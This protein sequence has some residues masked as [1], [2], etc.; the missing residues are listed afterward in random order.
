[1]R[2]G[3]V[4][5]VGRPAVGL[6]TQKFVEVDGLALGFQLL[7]T[8][9]RAT[10]NARCEDGIPSGPS[11]VAP[12]AGVADDRPDSRGRR[13][14]AD[15]SIDHAEQR[16]DGGLVCRERVDCTLFRFRF[17][18]GAAARPIV[19]G[20]RTGAA[21]PWRICGSAAGWRG[22]ARRW[23]AGASSPRGRR[24]SASYTARI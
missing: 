5:D 15:L 19:A 6:K 20:S 10:N 18:G 23:S 1:M 21:P 3:N 22:S 8:L 13:Q 14:V 16:D 17:E 2:A 12:A 4:A 7:G 24:R 9:L 11:Q